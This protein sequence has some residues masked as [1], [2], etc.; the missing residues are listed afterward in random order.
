MFSLLCIIQAKGLATSI[1][2]H[3]KLESVV[4]SPGLQVWHLAFSLS[5]PSGCSLFLSPH[6]LCEYGW[7]QGTLSGRRAF[8]KPWAGASVSHPQYTT[9][10]QAL[11][12]SCDGV[13][14]TCCIC[15]YVSS[16]I[17][18]HL[19]NRSKDIRSGSPNPEELN[20]IHFSQHQLP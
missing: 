16:L 20:R 19:F 5:P 13:V 6:C 2:C 18:S 1:P 11:T 14:Q 9:C 17:H 8:R 3:H 15:L 4:V 10:C 7:S 12:H